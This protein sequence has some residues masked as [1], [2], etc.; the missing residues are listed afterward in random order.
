MLILL[1]LLEKN[2]QFFSISNLLKLKATKMWQTSF[3]SGPIVFFEY[4]EKG[5]I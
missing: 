2:T 4:A 5:C 3:K 1:P